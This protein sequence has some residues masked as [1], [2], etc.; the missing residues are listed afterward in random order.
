MRFTLDLDNK[1]ENYIKRKA[2]LCQILFPECKVLYR[3]SSNKRGGHVAVYNCNLTWQESLQWRFLLGDDIK[4]I[5]KDRYRYKLGIPC[6]VLFTGKVRKGIRK[7]S[8]Q[9]RYI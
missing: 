8:I 7:E 5:S 2:E 6:Q 9:W 3:Q 4:R 1:K